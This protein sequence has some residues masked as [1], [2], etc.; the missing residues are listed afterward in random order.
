[1]KTK[2]NQMTLKPG[3]GQRRNDWT[4][5]S[6]HLLFFMSVSYVSRFLAR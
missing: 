3:L 5:V 2:L 6:F 1:M 4:L